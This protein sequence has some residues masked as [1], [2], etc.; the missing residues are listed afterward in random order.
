MKMV[1]SLVRLGRARRFLALL[2]G[3]SSWFLPSLTLAQASDMARYVGVAACAGCHAAETALWRESH[4]AQAMQPAQGAAVLGNFDGVT[5]LHEGVSTSFAHAHDG[6]SVR[7]E[8]PDGTEQTYRIAYTFGVSPLQQYLVAFPGGRY[9]ALGVAWDSRPK[10]SGGQRWFHLYPGQRFAA[11]DRLHWTGREQT[12]NHQCAACHTTDLRKNYDLATNTYATTWSELGV[13]CEACHGPGSDHVAW[14]QGQR[15]GTAN[16]AHSDFARMGIVA[17]LRATDGGRWEMNPQT[18]IAQRSKPLVSAEIDACAACHARRKVIAPRPVPGGPYLDSYLPVLL[19]PGLYHADGQIDGE[20]FEYGSFVQSRMF[21]A[22]VTCSDCHDPHSATLRATGNALCAQCHLP[23]RFD[24]EAHAH[25]PAGSAG[26][27]CVNCHMPTKTYMVVDARRDHSIRVPRPDLSLSLG[28]PNACTGC[29]ADRTAAWAAQAVAAW[30]PGGR[31]TRPHYGA[32]LHAGRLGAANA[33]VLLDALILDADQPPIA[34]ASALP[35]L[36]GVATAASDKAMLA[37][38]ADP[39]P[40][41]R[42]AAP[43]ALSPASAPAIL[44]TSLDLLADPVRA[45]RIEAARALAGIDPN[46]LSPGQRDAYE[47]AYREL[48][49]AEMVDADRPEAHL[50]LGL[51]AMRRRQPDIAEAEYRTALRLDP[52]FVPALVDLADLDRARG[53]DA[54]GAALLR[55]AMAIEPANADVR[56]ALGLLLARQ[57]DYAGA[58]PLLRQ[59]TEMAPASARYAYVYAIALN[60]AG[61]SKEAVALLRQAHLAHPAD[62]DLLAGLALIAR[63]AGDIPTAV[64]AAREMATSRPSD[65]RIRNLL[66][67]LEAGNPAQPR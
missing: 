38:I 5:L 23:A 42:A 51:L 36:Q 44:R 54:A 60:S 15:G 19:E 20:V 17:W 35:L 16:G 43:R 10:D 31:Q 48:V 45:V 2:A 61:Q 37:A 6:Y 34:R 56:H 13:S 22:G 24:T 64:Q 62:W 21:H 12:W 28:T 11:G 67:S 3:V 55:E 40:L 63:D 14:A 30:F 65:P 58:L 52:R 39:D 9:Q 26:A 53:Q 1:L 29:H 32:A 8:G 49:A 41:V 66:K 46:A 18:G 7:T 59:A 4:H 27:Q 33:E 50:N 57:H 25:H 47:V